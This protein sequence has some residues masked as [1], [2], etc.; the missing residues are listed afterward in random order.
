MGKSLMK[1]KN[2]RKPSIEPWVTPQS[3]GQHSNAWQSSDTKCLL[4]VKYD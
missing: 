3:I 2:Q 1:M 4:P